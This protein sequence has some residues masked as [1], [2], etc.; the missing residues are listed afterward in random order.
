MQE[1]YNFYAF[2]EDG[3]VSFHTIPSFLSEAGAEVLKK[4][5]SRKRKSGRSCHVRSPGDDTSRYL[6]NQAFQG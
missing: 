6:K 4:A 2:C 3:Q 5:G 1:K